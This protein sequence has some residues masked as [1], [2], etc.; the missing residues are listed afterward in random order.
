[1]NIGSK[2]NAFKSK[3]EAASQL[4]RKFGNLVGIEIFDFIQGDHL[5]KSELERRVEYFHRLAKDKEFNHLQDELYDLICRI[6]KEIDIEDVKQVQEKWRSAYLTPFKDGDKFVLHAPPPF[7][8][9]PELYAL[10]LDKSVY[11]RLGDRAPYRGL[12]GDILHALPCVAIQRQYVLFEQVLSHLQY[13]E[14]VSKKWEEVEFVKLLEAYDKTWYEF[15]DLIQAEPIKLHIESFIEFFYFSI[16][17]Y[18]RP[19][20]EH[21]HKFV[22]DSLYDGQHRPHKFEDAQKAAIVV[23]DDLMEL[24]YKSEPED[25]TLLFELTKAGLL[26]RRI[27]NSTETYAIEEGSLRHRLIK[28]LNRGSRGHYH[29]T[30][31]LAEIF[32]ATSTEIRK[33]VAD[34]KAQIKKSFRGLEGADF[35]EG[36]RNSGYRLAKNVRILDTN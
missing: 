18:P 30:D 28:E 19:K 31:D 9:L 29:N 6:L 1:M 4:D 12:E 34:I 26:S 27:G 8:E 36:K 20:F 35:I 15:S 5:L 23:I 14:K 7:R 13:S 17:V 21:W 3:V 32:S 22:R 16:A 33:S 11:Y 2:L 24:V 10:F 25:V